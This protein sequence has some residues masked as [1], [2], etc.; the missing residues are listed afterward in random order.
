MDVTEYERRLFQVFAV[1][2]GVERFPGG[3]I[4]DAWLEGDYPNTEI[5]MVVTFNASRDAALSSGPRSGRRSQAPAPKRTPTRSTSACR[6][7][8]ARLARWRGQ[9]AARTSCGR[10]AR[11]RDRGAPAREGR[12]E[13]ATSADPQ[14]RVGP[15]RDV[16]ACSPRAS[17]DAVLDRAGRRSPWCSGRAA[18][19]RARRLVDRVRS[20]GG[21]RVPALGPS[22]RRMDR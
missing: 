4:D 11:V 5:A 9:P 15:L 7:G 8:R 17:D 6:T 2:N 19:A 18:G 20:S 14:S 13:A 3:V 1:R 12:S 21:Q 10:R 16:P 22:S